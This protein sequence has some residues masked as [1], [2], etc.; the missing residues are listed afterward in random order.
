[1]VELGL[2]REGRAIDL[3]RAA[4][5]SDVP[6][7][8]LEPFNA[9]IEQQLQF[10]GVGMAAQHFD[11]PRRQAMAGSPHDMPARYRVAVAVQPALDP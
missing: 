8:D 2:H 9:M 3:G 4:N 5:P 7:S 11:H 10:P 1:M 6:G